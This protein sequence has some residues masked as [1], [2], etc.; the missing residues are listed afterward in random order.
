MTEQMSDESDIDDDDVL[1]GNTMEHRVRNKR[2][3]RNS[4]EQ[5]ATN[6][7]RVA[8]NRTPTANRSAGNNL[9]SMFDKAHR[10]ME[11]LEATDR[12][13]LDKKTVEVYRLQSRKMTVANLS[14]KVRTS[15]NWL[16]AAFLEH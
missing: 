12:H 16:A 10:E 13:T 8:T 2:Q 9:E 5:T 15:H 6:G 3:T 7:Q 11:T 4:S 14:G 1:E